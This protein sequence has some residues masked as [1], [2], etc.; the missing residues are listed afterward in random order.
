MKMEMNKFIELIDEFVD[1]NYSADGC[2]ECHE[3]GHSLQA[4]E[5]TD[6]RKLFEAI[7]GVSNE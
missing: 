5:Q 2:R 6:Y 4:D 1:E 3:T 7:K